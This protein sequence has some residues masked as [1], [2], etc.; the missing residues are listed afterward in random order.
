MEVFV[1]AIVFLILKISPLT[2]I[3]YSTYLILGY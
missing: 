1:S 2:P 3:T